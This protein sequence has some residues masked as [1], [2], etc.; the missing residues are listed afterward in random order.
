MSKSKLSSKTN[1]L[2]EKSSN[3]QSNLKIDENNI[4]TFN[5]EKQ[6]VVVKYKNKKKIKYPELYAY[7]V[8]THPSYTGL[9]NLP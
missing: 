1:V 6:P 3:R 2:I 5:T 9:K 7:D 8:S 4:K